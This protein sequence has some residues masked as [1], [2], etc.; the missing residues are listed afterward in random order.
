MFRISP[1]MLIDTSGHYKSVVV[2]F[3]PENLTKAMPSKTA[4]ATHAWFLTVLTF[5]P[6]CL[7]VFPQGILIVQPEPSD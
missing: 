6:I 1:S 5:Q 7:E 2:E 4:A 3:V